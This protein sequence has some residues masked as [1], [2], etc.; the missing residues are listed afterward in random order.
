MDH[1]VSACGLFEV[2]VGTHMIKMA[3]GIDDGYDGEFCVGEGF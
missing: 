3:V 1:D 2:F